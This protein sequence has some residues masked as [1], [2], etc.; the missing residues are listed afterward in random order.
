MTV[1]TLLTILDI[2]TLLRGLLGEY[3][4]HITKHKQAQRNVVRRYA[5]AKKQ[6][7]PKITK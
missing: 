4:P 6:K 7:Q 2:S 5:R 3:I 1:E